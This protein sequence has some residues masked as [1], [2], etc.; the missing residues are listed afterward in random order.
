MGPGFPS[1]QFFS[2]LVFLRNVFC[3]HFN[4]VINK[5]FFIVSVSWCFVSC[6][7]RAAA[8]AS[9]HWVL[10]LLVVFHSLLLSWIWNC[11]ITCRLSLANFSLF[12]VCSL[13]FSLV[14]VAE[15]SFFFISS[16]CFHLLGNRGSS[17]RGCCHLPSPRLVTSILFLGLLMFFIL[18]AVSF[19]PIFLDF[20][21]VVSSLTIVKLLISF[22]TKSVFRALFGGSDKL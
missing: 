10:H 8:V 7:N 9:L 15:L 20:L 14:V 12:C 5:V 16:K 13:I 22:T 6:P 2:L 1:Y 3:F 11:C 17:C 19:G 4:F 18:H 21:S